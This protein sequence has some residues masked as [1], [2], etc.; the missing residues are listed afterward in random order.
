MRVFLIMLIFFSSCFDPCMIE[1]ISHSSGA[2]L[3]QAVA[4]DCDSNQTADEVCQSEGSSKSHSDNHS[5]HEA[6]QHCHGGHVA[7]SNAVPMPTQ[8]ATVVNRYSAYAFNHD[9]PSYGTLRRPPK[10]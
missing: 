5:S 6:C 3:G 8:G 7:T 10:V 2:V 1:E 9:S 4:G